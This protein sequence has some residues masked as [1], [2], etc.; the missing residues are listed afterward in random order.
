MIPRVAAIAVLSAL[1][2]CVSAPP[3]AH[4]KLDPELPATWTAA[5]D[6]PPGLP[7]A[8]A[9][10]AGW[11]WRELGDARLES[12]VLEALDHNADLVAAAARVSRAAAQATITG[13]DSAPQ[14]GLAFA[15][16]RQKQ[17]FVGLPIPGSSGVLTS[18]SDSYGV[19]LDVSWEL[20][21]WG[22]IRSGQSAALAD[23]EAAVADFQG[24]RLSLVAQVAKAW[25]AAIEARRQVEL[26]VATVATYRS[27]L[28][29]VRDRYDRGLRPA[30]DLRLARSNLASAE[31][32]LARSRGL[33]DTAVRQLEILL[34]RYPARSLEA[35]AELP[36]LSTAAVPDFLPADLVSRRPDVVALERRLAAAGARVDAAR[37]ALYPRISLSASGGTSSNELTDLVDGDFSV[38]RL[39]ANAL[40]PIFQGGRLIAGID[41][42]EAGVREATA[43]YVRGA[44][45]AFAEVETGLNAEPVLG[46]T[47]S[48]LATASN[49]ASE[50]S[51]LSRER[52]ERGLDDLI[53]LL[54]AQRQAFD[55]ESRLLTVRR[56][57]LDARVDLHLA[58][59]GGFGRAPSAASGATDGTA[60]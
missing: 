52:Y 25:F 33:S 37:A 57:R 16:S 55:A 4:P 9:G 53:T 19:S 13:A 39:A 31:A 35:P 5:S 21:I 30:L 1:A 32:S 12:L 2:G 46:A 54:T 60:P 6:A 24:A 7:T 28:D 41:L 10:S 34:G 51:R 49:E 22:R 29:R 48:A 58:L 43:L 36:D 15:G 27:T 47:E 18:R 40:Q 44:L 45:H 3:V 26:A 11:W 17:N 59:G 20:D 23:R 50:A 38:W 14:I 8:K 56:Q 42:A